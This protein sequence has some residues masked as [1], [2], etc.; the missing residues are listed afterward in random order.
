MMLDEVGDYLR[1]HGVSSLFLSRMPDAPDDVVCLYEYGGPAPEFGHD[2]QQWENPRLQAVA[3]SKQ[4]VNARSA[5]QNV[6]NLLNGKSNPVFG[7]VPYLKCLAMQSPF[8]LLP[9]QNDRHR[10]VVN[11]ELAK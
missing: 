8:P 11:F 10:I 6:Y 3:R 7:G 2:G 1:T 4:Y 5:A 9:D